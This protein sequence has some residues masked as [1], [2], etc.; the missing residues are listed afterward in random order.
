MCWPWL[1]ITA[2]HLLRPK[3]INVLHSSTDISSYSPFKLVH[4][5]SIFL[6]FFSLALSFYNFQTFSIGFMSG[7][8]AGHSKTVTSSSERN[9][10]TDFAV[11][12]RVLSCMNTAGWWIAILKLGKTCFFNISLY[13]IM[14]ILPCS[15]TR[16]PVPS[17]EIMPNT[18]TLSPP[19]LILLFVHWGKC[20]SLGQ[21]QMN[22]LPSQP[23]RLNFDSLLKW[24]QS[25]CSSIH[26]MCSVANFNQLILFFL[27]M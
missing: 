7:I 3:R 20:C 14:L 9:V 17:S 11:W 8:W 26:M 15:L 21:C 4:S 23:N 6:G 5:S 25:H 24:K 16:D 18:I 2:W 27:E 10:L 22:L 12:H 19:N 13:T 1:S